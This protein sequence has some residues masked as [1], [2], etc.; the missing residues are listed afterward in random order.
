MEHTHFHARGTL[1]ILAERCLWVCAVVRALKQGSD[2]GA[3]CFR[4]C[5]Q[6]QLKPHTL[7]EGPDVW[8]ASE[9]AHPD[10]YSYTLTETDLQEIDAAV[11]RVHSKGLDIKVLPS[12]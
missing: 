11:E 6:G 10:S 5:R 4:A 12:V 2:S 7:V 3:L 9:Y 1:P 8:Y